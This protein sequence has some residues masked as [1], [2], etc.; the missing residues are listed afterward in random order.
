MTIASPAQ[1]GC[2]TALAAAVA[3]TDSPAPAIVPFIFASAERKSKRVLAPE[4]HAVPRHANRHVKGS[5]VESIFEARVLALGFSV[6]KPWCGQSVVDFVIERNGRLLRIQVKSAWTR[7]GYRYFFR[8]IRSASTHG[9]ARYYGTTIDFL[10]GFV[11]PLN[12]W[13]IIPAHAVGRHAHILV[14]PLDDVITH[15]VLGRPRKQRKARDYE[16]FR[17]AWH[18]LGTTSA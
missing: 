10:A 9:R 4:S 18:L 15:D 14:Y 3:S 12:A 16:H 6:Y 11:A 17:E 8:T 1:P 7:Y 2:A 5:W 13:Y